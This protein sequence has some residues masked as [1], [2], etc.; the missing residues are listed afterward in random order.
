MGEM[1]SVNERIDQETAALLV[2]ELGHTPKLVKGAEETLEADLATF[3]QYN[4]DA[5]GAPCASQ[6]R[7]PCCWPRLA[8]PPRRAEERRVG[9]GCVRRSHTR[10][11]R[12][13]K[14]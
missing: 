4:E 11:S 8:L 3:V 1:V 13:N 14:Q 12:D 2:E 10:W 7:P 6:R 5:L 9:K